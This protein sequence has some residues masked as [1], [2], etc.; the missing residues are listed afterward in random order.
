MDESLY[1]LADT[2]WYAATSR[3]TLENVKKLAQKRTRQGFTAI[4]LVAAYP[5]EVAVTSP[6][7][8]NSG[9]WPLTEAKKI[10][11][12]YFAE[13]DVKI[14]AITAAGL[15]PIIY[16]TWGNH[17]DALGP[18]SVQVLWEEVVKR[19]RSANPIWCL[20]GEVDLPIAAN[21]LQSFPFNTRLGPVL[22]ACAQPFKFLISQQ[23]LKQRLQAWSEIGDTVRSQDGKHPILVHTH[24][25]HTARELYPQATWLSANSFQSGHNRNRLAWLH[26]KAVA[27]HLQN[28]P[29]LNLEPWYE[30]IGNDFGPRLQRQAFWVSMLSGCIG[31]A[32]GAQGLWNMNQTGESFLGHW[33]NTDWQT[34][35]DAMGAAHIGN[36]ARWLRARNWYG[37]FTPVQVK[38]NQ[39]TDI[40]NQP[41]T[42]IAPDGTEVTYCPNPESR[43]MMRHHYTTIMDPENLL[44]RSSKTIT[45]PDCIILTRP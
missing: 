8:R 23:N 40:L 22:R 34:A 27:A 26:Q 16:G 43:K 31:Y 42:G 5:P 30:G 38:S 2:W 17:L 32:Y 14:R 35:A 6:H 13:L 33:G 3:M 1:F 37:R 39:L 18:A 24:V 7:A 21:V 12:Q 41:I 28:D 10:N 25:A 44:D 19:Y 11:Q 9:G 45:T 15:T 29:T 36:A 4:Q 20:C